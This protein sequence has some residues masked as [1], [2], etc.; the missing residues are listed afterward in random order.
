VSFAPRS[1][2]KLSPVLVLLVVPGLIVAGTTLLIDLCLGRHVRDALPEGVG[3]FR[4]AEIADEAQR[5]L[6]SQW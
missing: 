6:D 1:V 4:P 2:G 3:V 5:W